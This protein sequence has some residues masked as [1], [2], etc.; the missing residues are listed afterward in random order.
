[1]NF[2]NSECQTAGITAARFGLCDDEVG[3]AAYVDYDNETV[4]IATVVNQRGVVLIFTAVDK[5]VI[6]HGEQTGRGRCDVMLTSAEH[7]YFVE[8][9]SARCADN[10][11][12]KSQLVSTIQFFKEH[13]SKR[14]AEFKHR[15]A[16]L[17]NN[18]K[19]ARFVV[20]DNEEQT[21]FFREYG[22]RL[23]LQNEVLMV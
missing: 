12:G 23:D 9:K 22:F 20:I 19:R 8:L 4:W 5:C 14:L 21:R 10:A 17:C 7:L 1:M 2:F 13:H 11:H 3:E 6:K 15:K 18:K 16:F